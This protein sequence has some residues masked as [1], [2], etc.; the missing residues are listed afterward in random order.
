[1]MA[2]GTRTVGIRRSRGG[3][4]PEFRAVGIV[5]GMAKTTLACFGGSLPFTILDVR[6]VGQIVRTRQLSHSVR[7]TF[8]A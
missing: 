8:R 2:R 6:A 3:T 5:H 4:D 1:M 7:V